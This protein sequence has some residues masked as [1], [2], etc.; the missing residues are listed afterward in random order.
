MNYTPMYQPYQYPVFA[1]QTRPGAFGQ[2]GGY[3]GTALPAQNAPAPVSGP[4][5]G[6]FLVQPVTSREEA[7][8]VIADPMAAGVLMPDLGHGV[9]YLKRFN[10]QTGASDFGEFALTAPRQEPAAQPAE[11]LVTLSVFNSTVERLREE[12]AAAKKT[13]GKAVKKDDPDE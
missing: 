7:L 3:P 1:S 6:G 13:T 8:A 11:E 4:Q 5:A 12:I 2:A 9:I 10:S